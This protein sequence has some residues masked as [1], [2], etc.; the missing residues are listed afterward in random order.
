MARDVARKHWVLSFGLDGMSFADGEDMRKPIALA[1]LLSISSS[2]CYFG[3][4][5]SQKKSAVVANLA[6]VGLGAILV[7]AETRDSGPE[8]DD[9]SAP[10]GYSGA[11]DILGLGIAALGVG[12]IAGGAIGL[13]ANAST[14]TVPVVQ[15]E[16]RQRP[17]TKAH[18]TAPGLRPAAVTISTGSS[19]GSGL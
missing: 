16:L 10:H 15:G 12:L 5:A 6:A 18:V 13:I 17:G 9:D 2:G 11:P 4:Q 1:L 14:P 3:R 8:V 7:Y 19:T